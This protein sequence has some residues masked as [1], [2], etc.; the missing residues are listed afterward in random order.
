MIITVTCNRVFFFLNIKP[1]KY[2]VPI[3]SFKIKQLKNHN[4]YF[5]SLLTYLP[6]SYLPCL[7]NFQK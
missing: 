6:L 2:T 7:K 5:L 4:E 1:G 3:I